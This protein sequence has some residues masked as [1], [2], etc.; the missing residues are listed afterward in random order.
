MSALQRNRYTPP[1]MPD[2][3]FSRDDFGMVAGAGLELSLGSRITGRL[4]WTYDAIARDDLDLWTARGRL[5]I[6]F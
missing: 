2:G 6:R 5:Q 1:T 3:T 4:E